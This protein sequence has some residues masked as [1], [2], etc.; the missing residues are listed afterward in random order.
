MGRVRSSVKSNFAFKKHEACSETNYPMPERL[1]RE[2]P[3]GGV[4]V[5]VLSTAPMNWCQDQR[6]DIVHIIRVSFDGM[7]VA[8]ATIETSETLRVE[9]VPPAN[10]APP[11]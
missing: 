11:L 3:K 4:E 8:T 2:Y 1:M 5:Q 9:F 7:G 6:S 10:A